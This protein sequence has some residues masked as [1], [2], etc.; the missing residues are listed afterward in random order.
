MIIAGTNKQWKQQNDGE[1]IG[2]LWA[3]KNINFDVTGYAKLA[4]RS[5]ALFSG[6]TNTNDVTSI[7]TLDGTTYYVMSSNTGN[8]TQGLQLDGTNS[9]IAN[10]AV[11][12]AKFD[13]ITWQGRWYVSQD[14][15]FSYFDGSWTTGLGTLT[16]AKYHPLCVHEGLNYLAIGDGNTVLLYNTSHSLVLTI[17]L[18]SNFEVIHIRY[19]NNNLYIGTRNIKSGNSMLFVAD[20]TSTSANYGIT[21]PSAYYSFSA[22]IHEGVY[23]TIVSSGQILKF[24]GSG[25]DEAAHLP[26]Y[27]TPYQWFSGTGFDT[28]KVAQRGMISKNGRIYMNIDGYIQSPNNIQL[29]NQPSGLWCLDKNV[30]LYHLA[31]VSNETIIA[32]T[33]SSASAT[34]HIITVTNGSAFTVPTGTK[35]FISSTDIGGLTTGFYYIIWLSTTTF[36]LATT[37]ANAI[38]FSEITLTSNGSNLTIYI[39]ADTCFGESMQGSYQ[40]GALIVVGETNQTI[41]TNREYIAS[42]FLFGAATVNSTTGTGIYTIQSL[43]VGENRGVVTTTKLTNPQILEAWQKLLVKYER[44]F[45]GNDKIIIKYRNSTKENYPLVVSSNMTWVTSTSFTSSFDWSQTS[46]GDEIEFTSGRGAGCRVHLVSKTNNAGTWTV[47]VD[48]AIPGVVANDVSKFAFVDNWI[49]DST[50]DYKHVFNNNRFAKNTQSCVSSKWI[51]YRVELRGV[52]EPYLEELQAI[53]SVQQP[54][55]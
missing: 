24:N 23:H 14:V 7:G 26:V 44:L 41:S 16:T 38:A 37:Y 45:Q 46:I 34:S 5:I 51:Q 54:S 55:E 27:N 19:N 42:Q 50:I 29:P 22:C 30:G 13:G 32:P 6:L 15:H 1:V 28:G 40:P 9:P 21:I 18:P 25:F 4:R 8:Q 53:T 12:S 47:V 10:G 36:R 11:G 33:F 2:S 31:G 49:K 43:C 48:E 52:S 17:T 39:H 3:T 35:V 20:G